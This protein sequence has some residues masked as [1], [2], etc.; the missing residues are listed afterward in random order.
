M[1]AALQSGDYYFSSLAT[2]SD[3]AELVE[4]FIA[5]LPDRVQRLNEASRNADWEIVG[6]I[7]HQLKGAAGSYGLHALT[8]FAAR[9]E[10][11]ARGNQPPSEIQN[12]LAE[13]VDACGRVRPGTSSE[14]PR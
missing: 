12:A 14:A 4:L 2:D 8:P 10:T 11:A 3:L 5:E 9:L 6:R 1:N 13:M 7:A